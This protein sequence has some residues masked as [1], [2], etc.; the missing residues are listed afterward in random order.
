MMTKRKNA[1]AIPMFIVVCLLGVFAGGC[2]DLLH[3]EGPSVPEA[4]GGLV[5][6]V[7]SATEIRVSWNT[8]ERADSYQVFYGEDA[9]TISKDGGQTGELSLTVSGLTPNTHYYFAV[10][11]G[12]VNGWS[13][14]SS[15]VNAVTGQVYTVTVSPSDHGS[16]NSSTENAGAGT[17]VT[18][19]VNPETDYRLKSLIVKD[20]ANTDVAVNGTGASRTFTMPASNVTVGAEFELGLYS[21]T[22]NTASH[23]SVAA[24][25]VNAGEGRTVT[26]TISPETGYQ[27]TSLT[28]KNAANA[29]V[30]VS[31]TGANRTFTMPASNVTVNAVFE[32][33]PN[34][35][36]FIQDGETLSSISGVDSPFSIANALYWLATNAQADTA[37]TIVID[38]NE[39]LGPVVLNSTSLN[40]KTGVKITLRGFDTERT[41]QLSSKGS[42]FTVDNGITLNLDENITLKGR[43]DNNASLVNIKSGAALA[44]EQGSKISG[45]TSSGS[46]TGGGVTVSDTFTMNGG[47]ISGNANASSLGG[48]VLFFGSSDKRMI[49]T[50]NGGKI[51]GNTTGASGNGGGVYFYSYGTFTMSGGEIS[52]NTAGSGGGVGL[53]TNVT[54]T[55]S[56]GEISGNAAT[57]GLGKGGG[58]YVWGSGSTFTMSGGEIFGNTAVSSGGGVHIASSS[59]AFKK[60]PAAGSNISG[61]IYGYAAGDQKS[62]TVANS[63][64]VIQNDRGHAVY[65]GIGAPSKK[66]ETTAGAAQRMDSAVAGAAGG[67]E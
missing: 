27:L 55:M 12:N 67:W 56:G 40:G 54:F 58:V 62:N 63:V 25:P 42:L 15:S 64:G 52:G 14:L 24:N 33:M 23:G 6:A 45:N 4:P 19:T 2:Q 10:R 60:Q 11:A 59:D 13:P 41:V 46:F 57:N 37:Y 44:M 30:T 7:L 9:E 8:A 61:V 1:T 3:P 20:A 34:Y 47:E 51:S 18:L 35:G 26:L 38:A 53:N 5:P 32:E 31:G 28:V 66:R 16:V 50:M 65:I 43:S 36:L 29:D 48:G 22:V 21:V 17:V 49:F 39:T